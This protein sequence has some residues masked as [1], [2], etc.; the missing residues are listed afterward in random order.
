MRKS[1][2]LV[3]VLLFAMGV[4][5]TNCNSPSQKVENA[6]TNAAEAQEDLDQARQDYLEDVEVYK[7]QT[8]EKIAANNKSIADFNAR[9]ET[10]KAEAKAE[11]KLKIA[12][13]EK[14]NS[15]MQKKLDDY[16]VESKD[17]WETF[18]S[19]FNRDMDQL[20]NALQD[21]TVKNN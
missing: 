15:D 11:Y 5:F 7:K 12:E 13:L 20:G 6:E 9:I 1:I 17:Q 8:A 18:K 19:E 2:L 14:K 3:T 16:K 10:E 4:L 21:L